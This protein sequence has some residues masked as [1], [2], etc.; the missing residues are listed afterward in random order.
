MLQVVVVGIIIAIII[1]RYALDHL[2]HKIISKGYNALQNAQGRKKN[3][4]LRGKEQSLAEL[5]GKEVSSDAY[6]A[7]A[8][9]STPDM[10]L[11]KFCFQ[12]GKKI[13]DGQFCPYCGADQISG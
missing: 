6:D 10:T 2:T 3:E 7:G 13:P 5:Y 11:K 4:S 9:G 12:C 8:S 1:L